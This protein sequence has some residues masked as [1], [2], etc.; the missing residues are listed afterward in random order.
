M[1]EI[2][3]F[4]DCRAHRARTA[5]GATASARAVTA[6]LVIRSPVAVGVRQVSLSAS[7]RTTARQVCDRQSREMH[8]V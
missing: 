6:G 2:S 5:Q 3:H 7:A 8:R 1:P 4:T